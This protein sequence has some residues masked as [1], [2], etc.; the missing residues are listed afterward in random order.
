MENKTIPYHDILLPSQGKC[1]PN[2]TRTITVSELTVSDEDFIA[3]PHLYKNGKLIDTIL[4]RKIMSLGVRAKDLVKGDKDAIALRL[5]QMAYGNDYPVIVIHPETGNEIAMTVQLDNF[6]YKPFTLNCDEN[7]YFEYV[8]PDNG[9]V[10]KFR[11][12]SQREEEDLKKECLKKLTSVQSAH[13][14]EKID[15]IR[16]IVDK[17]TTLTDGDK[18]YIHN[19]ITEALDTYTKTDAGLGGKNV[20]SMMVEASTELTALHTVAVNGN[21]DRTA[22]RQ[23]A[24]ALTIKQA[25]DYRDFIASNSPGI[26]WN[27]KVKLLRINNKIE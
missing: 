20:E 2:G 16:N 19:L 21:T 26:D 12:P 17:T 8:M 25:S 11:Y 4:E 14:S 6:K 10:V 15:E 22:I 9:T 1:Y 7:G 18:N 24:N 3:N 23:W 5:R 27:F 13:F